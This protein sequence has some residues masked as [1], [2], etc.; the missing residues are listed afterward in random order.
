MR[1]AVFLQSRSGSACGDPVACPRRIEPT[2]GYFRLRP[3]GDIESP[4]LSEI[5]QDHV[6]FRL[7][8]VLPGVAR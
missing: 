1:F 3:A 8:G 6:G 2:D 4:L 7:T 5:H